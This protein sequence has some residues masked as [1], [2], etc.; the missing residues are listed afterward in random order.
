[1]HN[2][3]QGRVWTGQQ[4]QSN[5]LIDSVGDLR[6]AVDK[7]KELAKVATDVDPIL[8]Y[9]PAPKSPLEMIAENLPLQSQG[10]SW[11]AM[12]QMLQNTLRDA[13]R[14]K[15]LLAPTFDIR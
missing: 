4:A 1:M 14:P 11:S 2:V 8:E 9:Y 10:P 13:N 12:T 3:A 15:V 5:G 7:L 6:L